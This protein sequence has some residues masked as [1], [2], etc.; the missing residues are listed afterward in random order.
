[1]IALDASVVIPTFSAGDPDN[2]RARQVIVEGAAE[3]FAMSVLTLAETL[4]HQ[5]EGDTATRA[6]QLVEQ[7]GV[8]V[9]PIRADQGSQLAYLRA[10]TRLKMPD[11]VVLALA[12]ECGRLATFDTRLARTAAAM[13]VTVVGR[14]ADG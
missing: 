8:Q 11:A 7:M 13:G 10:T 14:D 6:E 12:L 3:G 4:V 5:V 1:L 2:A 9:R